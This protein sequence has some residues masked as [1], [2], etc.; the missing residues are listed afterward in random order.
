MAIVM[1]WLNGGCIVG[2]PSLPSRRNP[3]N[4]NNHINDIYLCPF[5]FTGSSSPFHHQR[6]RDG[7]NTFTDT[8]T[9][10]PSAYNSIMSAN[11]WNEPYFDISVPNNVTAL[12]GKSAYLSCKVRNLGNKTVSATHFIF[13]LLF[14]MAMNEV[15]NVTWLAYGNRP[16]LIFE[17]STMSCALCKSHVAVAHGA[18][19]VRCTFSVSQ[20]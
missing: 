14:S 5:P 4:R 1:D 2:L 12:V 18:P 19:R 15:Q 6:P 9:I 7:Y 8:S 3:S 10:L 16:S 13:P 11:K 17:N 20:F